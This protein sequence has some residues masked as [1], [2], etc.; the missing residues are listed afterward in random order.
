MTV[1]RKLLT[2]ATWVVILL[3]HNSST[4]IAMITTINSFLHIT[5][6]YHA[7]APIGSWLA[8]RWRVAPRCVWVA[9]W[10]D[11]WMAGWL[12][13]EWEA[14]LIVCW[15][16]GWIVLWTCRFMADSW[17][18][19][20]MGRVWRGRYGCSWLAGSPCQGSATAASHRPNG[21]RGDTRQGTARSSWV[22]VDTSGKGC[23][24]Y[25]NG[26]ARPLWPQHPALSGGV[27]CGWA[28]ATSTNQG[29]GVNC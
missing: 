13:W 1:I 4:T 2:G 12:S 5:D 26:A 27:T 17:L 8:G 28:E 29:H 22:R 19:R 14:G 24:D 20:W 3:S 21:C 23:R 25:A 11:G 6:Q 18:A 7:V 15:L 16:G 9:E 10:M